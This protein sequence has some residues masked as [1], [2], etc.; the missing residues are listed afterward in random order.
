MVKCSADVQILVRCAVNSTVMGG[1]Y[2]V[3]VLYRC[4]TAPGT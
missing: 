2:I 4:N 1:M 3:P